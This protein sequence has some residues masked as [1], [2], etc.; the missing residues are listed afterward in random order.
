M[1]LRDEIV[2]YLDG[3][4]LVAPWLAGP[5]SGESSNNGVLYSS[6]YYIFLQMLGQLTD[7]DKL[8]WTNK[9]LSCI[10][11][12]NLL[13]RAPVPTDKNL[14]AQDDYFG[15][16]TASLALGNTDIPRKFLWNIIKYVGCLNNASPGTWTV[17]S[18]LARFFPL[19]PCMVSAAFPSW[20]NPLHILARTAVMPLFWI[21]AA[22]IATG[23]MFST[24]SDT[25]GRILTWHY[26]ET[27][28]PFSLSCWLAS[29]LWNSRLI[30]AYGSAGMKAVAAIYYQA[31]HPFS[32]YWPN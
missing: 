30:G 12:S 19:I 25:D 11:S 17:N 4:G 23:G 13:N 5:A 8:D 14:E 16:L 20:K 29:K 27:L 15:I 2:P 6:Q 31:G 28:K 22:I 10:D 3:N 7:Q 26:Q 9:M 21:S 18:F 32:K 1:A 24:T